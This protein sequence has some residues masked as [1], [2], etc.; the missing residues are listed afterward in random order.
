M[1]DADFDRTSGAALDHQAASDDSPY[2]RYD[3]LEQLQ[4]ELTMGDTWRATEQATREH[5]DD[6]DQAR[7]MAGML[8]FANVARRIGMIGAQ[9]DLEAFLDLVRQDDFSRL[10]GVD[11]ESK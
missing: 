7:R 10:M 8:A 2:L 3:Q 1:T 4:A 9:V 5:P 11:R 6:P